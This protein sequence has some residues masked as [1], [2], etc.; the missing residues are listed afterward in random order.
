MYKSGGLGAEVGAGAGMRALEV[1]GV[2]VGVSLP[3]VGASGA[4]PASYLCRSEGGYSKGY[5]K[6]VVRPSA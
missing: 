6:C 4:P 1:V 5:G 3:L 2:G